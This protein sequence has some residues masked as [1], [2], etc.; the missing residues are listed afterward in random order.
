[1]VAVLV[2]VTV[3]LLLELSSRTRVRWD[4][5]QEATATLQPETLAVLDELDAQDVNVRVTAFSA[6]AR[7]NEAVF[8]DR[9]VRDFLRTLQHASPWVETQFVDMDRD[10]LTAEQLGVSRYG[11]IVVDGRGDR[12]DIGDR[13]IFRRRGTGSSRELEFLGEA[14]IA[15]GVRQVLA[16]RDRR[17]YVLAGHGERTLFDRGLGELKTIAR[18]VDEQGWSFAPLDLLADRADGLP[19]AVPDDASAVIAL[20]PK[21]PLT[22]QE[23]EALRAYLVGGGSLG[24]FIDP[25]GVLPDFAESLGVSS[26]AGVVLSKEFVYPF[27]DR[28]IVHP[29]RHPITTVLI[30]DDLRAEVA[31]AAPLEMTPREGVRADALLQTSR[32]GWIER[33]GERPAEYTPG[34][35]VE[36]PV[37]VAY[38]LSLGPP[39]PLGRGGGRVVMVGDVD[40]IG[41]E[42]IDEAPGN[43]SL[44]VNLMRWLVRADERIARV[45]RPG[46]IRRLAM[47]PEQLGRV[48]WLVMAGLPLF[49]VLL[50]GLVR[51][52]RGRR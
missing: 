2:V 22:L 27:P 20:G 21:H 29:R 52:S 41:D 40:I 7:N 51:W 8:K 49:V 12:V 3:G 35:D 6:Q 46:R 13:E 38:A 15:R 25:D 9:L 26:P 19:P 34:V 42:V 16:D 30:E 37:M 5:T 18:L 48:R 10:R 14:A 24:W 11:T 33:S 39:H 32:G 36:G 50:G 45:G 1:V 4:L 43:R 28:P 44:T 17:I 23:E 47:T 31:Y